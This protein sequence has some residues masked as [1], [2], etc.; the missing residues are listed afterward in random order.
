MRSLLQSQT[1][2]HG[3][4][5]LRHIIH[6]NGDLL[7][8]CRM[9]IKFLTAVFPLSLNGKVDTFSSG[10]TVVCSISQG[11]FV[12]LTF[13]QFQVFDG[14]LLIIISVMAFSP[15]PILP[16]ISR[17]IRLFISTAYSSGSSFDTLSAN[18]LTRSAL[19]SSS[20]MPLDIK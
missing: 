7:V 18:P 9:N 14:S 6:I 10:S 2:V 16:F 3:K 11:S 20:L 17:R 13:S 1:R 15:Y 19:A 8:L 4:L 12:S 5:I